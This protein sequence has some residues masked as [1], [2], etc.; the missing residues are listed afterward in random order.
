MSSAKLQDI[1]G[2][3]IVVANDSGLIALLNSLP[4][5][6]V[7]E[8]AIVR[9]GREAIDKASLFQPDLVVV[10]EKMGDLSGTE[11]AHR[12]RTASPGT[13]VMVVGSKR[14]N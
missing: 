8:S 11:V 10:T 9:D 14:T 4:N 2:V 3:R 7:E 13:V 6:T 5:G 12:I 1:Y